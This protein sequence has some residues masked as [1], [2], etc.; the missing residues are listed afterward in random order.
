MVAL[1]WKRGQPGGVEVADAVSAG[2]GAPARR[3]AT[4][5]Y[6]M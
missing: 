2:S 3:T 6:K 4:P 5:Y 1:L